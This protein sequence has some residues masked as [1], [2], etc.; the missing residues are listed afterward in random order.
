MDVDAMSVLSTTSFGMAIRSPPDTLTAFWDWFK[1]NFAPYHNTLVQTLMTRTFKCY[2]LVDLKMSVTTFGPAILIDLLGAEQ[3]DS[4]W[5]PLIDLHMIFN[6]ALKYFW[7]DPRIQD[8]ISVPYSL[9][10]AY[11]NEVYASM[12]D[13]FPTSSAFATPV[14]GHEARSQRSSASEPRTTTYSRVTPEVDKP[15]PYTRASSVVQ[16]YRSQ[17]RADRNR[18]AN[19]P[20][21][22]SYHSYPPGVIPDIPYANPVASSTSVSFQRGEDALHRKRGGTTLERLYGQQ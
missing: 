13:L 20:H 1:T 14:I 9:W 4:L 7:Y 21:S 8:L 16:A 5:I 11:R 6:F 19:R 10:L 3:Y 22:S 17:R 15:P 2:T 18:A 12:H